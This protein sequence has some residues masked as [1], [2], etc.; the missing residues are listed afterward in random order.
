MPQVADVPQIEAVPRI[1]AASG[2]VAAPRAVAVGTLKVAGPRCHGGGATTEVTP[3]PAPAPRAHA[4]VSNGT[5]RG[6]RVSVPPPAPEPPAPR[7][8]PDGRP[9]PLLR[10]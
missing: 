3:A 6:A 1:E 9:E 7:R 8:V 2:S 4:W 5:H 10:V